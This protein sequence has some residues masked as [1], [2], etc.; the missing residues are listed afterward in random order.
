L[1]K[2]KINSESQNKDDKGYPGTI[3]ETEGF[4]KMNSDGMFLK[5][6]LDDSDTYHLKTSS[7]ENEDFVIVSHEIWKYLEQIYGGIDV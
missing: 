5:D 1:K 6:P 4:D 7:K 2:P 3:N